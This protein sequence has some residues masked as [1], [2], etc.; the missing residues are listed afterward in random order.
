RPSATEG[1][2][3][4]SVDVEAEEVVLALTSYD[5]AGI[6]VAAEHDGGTSDLVV[7][8]AHRVA[9]CAGD[10]GGEHVA[11]HEI[12][13]DGCVAHEQVARLAVLAD[14]G[15]DLVARRERRSRQEG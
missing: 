3:H 15:D 6:A 12:S 9:V 10:R 14:D 11:H 13:R 8:A 1:S 7:V 5:E 4:A 2:D